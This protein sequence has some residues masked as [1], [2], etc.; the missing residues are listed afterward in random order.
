ME[1][2]L[3]LD[4]TML[5]YCFNYNHELLHDCVMHLGMLIYKLSD[6]RLQNISDT[7]F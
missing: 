3:P 5:I 1:E 4:A 6:I 7:Y 2:K